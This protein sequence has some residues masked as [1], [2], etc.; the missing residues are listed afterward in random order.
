[1]AT[2]L[3]ALKNYTSNERSY[4]CLVHV[5]KMTEL[6][7]MFGVQLT[8]AQLLAIF[9][10][11]V[12]Y[13]TKATDNEEKSAQFAVKFLKGQ[14]DIDNATITKVSQIIIDTKDHKPTIEESRAVIDLDLAGLAMSWEMY[15]ENF[16]CIQWEYDDLSEEEF[17][18][19]RIKFLDKML[20]KPNIYCGPLALGDMDKVAKDNMKKEMELLIKFLADSKAKKAKETPE[21]VELAIPTP[22]FVELATP[23]NIPKKKEEKKNGKKTGNTEKD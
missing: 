12:V 22:E 23:I 20:A 6:A 14:E 5:A 16:N 9:F 19:G 3:E 10:H 4:H 13:N 17:A 7:K 8:D 18:E 1:M 21:F 15:M 11:D 2:L